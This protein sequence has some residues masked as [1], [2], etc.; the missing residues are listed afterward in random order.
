MCLNDKNMDTRNDCREFFFNPR[1]FGAFPDCAFEFS[2]NVF[3]FFYTF[4][5]SATPT[6]SFFFSRLQFLLLGNSHFPLL[7]SA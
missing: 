7:F 4:D 2:V 6:R 5:K 3:F 1:F